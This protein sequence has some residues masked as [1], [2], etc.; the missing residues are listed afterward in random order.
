MACIHSLAVRQQL[1]HNCCLL[2]TLFIQGAGSL[3]LAWF[4][5]EFAEQC[6]LEYRSRPMWNPPENW[7]D[8]TGKEQSGTGLVKV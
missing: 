4:G 6:G 1:Q 5:E 7:L 2:V 8:P 3:G